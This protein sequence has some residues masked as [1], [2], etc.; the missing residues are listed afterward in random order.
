MGM[1]RSKGLVARRSVL[2]LCARRPG[3]GTRKRP[4]RSP[5]S[6]STSPPRMRSPPRRTRWPRLRSAVSIR[7]CGGSFR[8]ASIQ[9]CLTFS[10][11]RSKARS[12]ASPSARSNIPRRATS[13]RWMSSS[14]KQAVK[15]LVTSLGHANQRGAGADDLDPAARHRR[16]QGEERG[17]RPLA[18]GLAQSRPHAWAYPSDCAAAAARARAGN[19]QGGACRRRRA[20]LPRC[21]AT[22]GAPRWSSPSGRA[23]DG[24]QFITRLAGTDG[25]GRINYGRSDKFEGAPPKALRSRPPPSPMPSWR[26]AG[27][28]RG[29]PRSKWRRCDMRRECRP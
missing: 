16:Q 10:Q 21:R 15:Q 4:I 9:S 22:M 25:V 1:Q 24:G 2:A 26:T 17:Q 13:R 23:E 12:T 6:P 18:P 28:R 5:R 29:R 11:S 3:A 8:S 14:T 27:R 19:G 7:C 20:P